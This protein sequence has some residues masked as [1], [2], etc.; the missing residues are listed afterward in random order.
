M[1]PQRSYP[2]G[3]SNDSGNPQEALKRRQQ[4]HQWICRTAEVNA[5]QSTFFGPNI[6]ASS[7]ALLWKINNS[8]KETVMQDLPLNLL[9]G[10][11]NTNPLFLELE[12][13][14]AYVEACFDCDVSSLGSVNTRTPRQQGVVII[15]SA[16]FI[17]QPTT[18]FKTS[19][20]LKPSFLPMSTTTQ[21]M[22]VK[23]PKLYEASLSLPYRDFLM[24]EKDTSVGLKQSKAGGTTS[25]AGQTKKVSIEDEHSGSG[26]SRHTLSTER[27][28]SESGHSP[29]SSSSPLEQQ[30][31]NSP[32]GSSIAVPAMN[33]DERFEEMLSQWTSQNVRNKYA[34]SEREQ[35]DNAALSDATASRQRQAPEAPINDMTVTTTQP[36]NRLRRMSLSSRAASMKDLCNSKH[37]EDDNE[38]RSPTFSR[39]SSLKNLSILSQCEASRSSVRKNLSVSKPSGSATYCQADPESYDNKNTATSSCPNDSLSTPCAVLPTATKSRVRNV[40]SERRKSAFS[41][42]ILSDCSSDTGKSNKPTLTGRKLPGNTSTRGHSCRAA[43]ARSLSSDAE[44]PIKSKRQAS[45]A[46]TALVLK[47]PPLKDDHLLKL[48]HRMSSHRSPNGRDQRNK[49]S[50]SSTSETSSLYGSTLHDLDGEEIESIDR[51]MWS[52]RSSSA[53]DLG[54]GVRH[55][56]PL[57]KNSSCYGSSLRDL[58]DDEVNME[59]S[60]K[61]QLS[62]S[63]DGS[64]LRDLDDE[65][66]HAQPPAISKRRKSRS[67][68]P[69]KIYTRRDPN[70]QEKSTLENFLSSSAQTRPAFHRQGSAKSVAWSSDVKSAREPDKNQRGA[71]RSMSS[72]SSSLS[73]LFCATRDCSNYVTAPDIPIQ[74]RAGRGRLSLSS[75]SSAVSDHVSSKNRRRSSEKVVRGNPSG[76][77]AS[78]GR[79]RVPASQ[80]SLPSNQTSSA[81]KP[82]RSSSLSHEA[83]GA[84]KLVKEASESSKHANPA[85]KRRTRSSSLTDLF[86]RSKPK[87]TSK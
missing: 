65:N 10:A 70:G 47:K 33:A 36:S 48:G 15:D 61:L 56:A 66:C 82:R 41:S 24:S 29:H 21:K 35:Q 81:V 20:P 50:N 38:K 27:S 77:T 1:L 54:K 16:G 18:N 5:V 58:D 62:S 72:R 3:Q 67:R 19:K 6:V 44:T 73:D 85:N 84:V 49:K 4:R 75:C 8:S 63:V 83:A 59:S 7:E 64:F 51:R 2:L 74:N 76:R 69:R 68:A 45:L 53:R 86:R 12:R 78:R 40:S 71:R 30:P 55:R 60:T 87:A 9:L 26:D 28:F 57:T 34:S 17:V 32:T 37:S 43:S 14:D 31:Q 11:D 79:S 42:P 22:V 13:C 25:K 39:S 46:Q 23:K 52:H 80:S